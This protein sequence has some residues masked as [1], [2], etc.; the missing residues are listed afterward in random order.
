MS[1]V[2]GCAP[3]PHISDLIYN[4]KPPSKNPG[5][6][7]L[8]SYMYIYI[9]VYVVIHNSYISDIHKCYIVHSFRYVLASHTVYTHTCKLVH[10]FVGLELLLLL[11]A[12]MHCHQYLKTAISIRYVSCSITIQLCHQTNGI[13]C[14]WNAHS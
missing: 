6:A 11:T 10:V 7:P 3:D 5:Y 1:A 9:Q 4:Q 12:D 2:G 13:R 14:V 8:H